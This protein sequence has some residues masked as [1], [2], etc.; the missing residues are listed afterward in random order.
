MLKY[1][2]EH[3]NTK[4]NQCSFTCLFKINYFFTYLCRRFSFVSLY[5]YFPLSKSKY[6]HQVKHTYV[7]FFPSSEHSCNALVILSW[8]CVANSSDCKTLFLV[9]SLLLLV[10]EEKHVDKDT[11][12]EYSSDTLLFWQKFLI[13]QCYVGWCI[14]VV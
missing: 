4:F 14:I 13:K 3:F 8:A 10:L 12:G 9:L 11:S 6:P 1:G 5:L 7:T 2:C